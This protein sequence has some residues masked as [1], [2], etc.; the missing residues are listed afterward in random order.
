[1]V[2]TT[3]LDGLSLRDQDICWACFSLGKDTSPGDGVLLLTLTCRAL[4]HPTPVALSLSHFR[5]ELRGLDMAV[6]ARSQQ[7]QKPSRRLGLGLNPGLAMMRTSH[8]S[9]HVLSCGSGHSMWCNFGSLLGVRM[10]LSEV[11]RWDPGSGGVLR[12]HPAAPGGGSQ[13]LTA[14]ER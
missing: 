6:G 1:M 9:W 13:L 11:A 2:P 3:V 5:C 8:R 14:R 10:E 4:P 7:E 12:T